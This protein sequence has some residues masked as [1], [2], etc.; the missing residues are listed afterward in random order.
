[1]RKFFAIAR[2]TALEMTCEPLALLLTLSAMALAVLTPVMHYHQFGEASRMARDAGLSALLVFGIAYGVFCTVKSIRR[3][4]DS[5]TIEMALAHSVSRAQFFLAKIAGAA[6]AYFVFAATVASVSLIVVNGA[7][8][9]GRIAKRTGDVAAVFGPSRV[10]ALVAMVG[11][12]AFAAVLNRFCRFRFTLSATVLLLG[13]S[14]AGLAPYFDAK[15][16]AR[17]LP[18]AAELTLPALVFIA[19]SA[20]F[21]VRWRENA[22]TTA[23]GGLFLAAMP[24]LGN[25]YLSDVLSKGGSLPLWHPALAVLATLPSIAAFAWLGVSLLEGRDVGGT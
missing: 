16:A 5:G 25:Y 18:V 9:G 15:L 23:A 24:L 4:I 19:A 13:L 22:A 17:F 1:M 2:A 6:I 21:A 7:E 8:I 12:V 10:F 3:E 14:V 20:A 11:G